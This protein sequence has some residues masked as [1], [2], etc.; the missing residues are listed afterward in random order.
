MIV[1]AWLNALRNFIYGDAI[2]APTHIAVGTGTTA[3]LASDTALETEIHPDGANRN[4]ITTRTKPSSRK[5]RLQTLIT[6]G[7]ANGHVL[8]EVGALNA[9]TGGTLMNRVVHTAINKDASFELKVQIL[10]EVSDV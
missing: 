6:A 2:T 1:D 7:E 9:A 3:A 4:A 10:T 8:T 5:V